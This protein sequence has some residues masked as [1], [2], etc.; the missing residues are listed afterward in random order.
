IRQRSS[1][2]VA[3]EMK[4]IFRVASTGDLQGALFRHELYRKTNDVPD[5]GVVKLSSVF[6]AHGHERESRSLLEQH[7]EE[8]GG[9]HRLG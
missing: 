5:W 2:S 1:A 3:K 9:H 6:L 8:T 4:E 7:Y